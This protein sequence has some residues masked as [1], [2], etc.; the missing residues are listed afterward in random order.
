VADIGAGQDEGDVQ[1]LCDGLQPLQPLLAGERG[2]WVGALPEVEV[3]TAER[4]S[5]RFPG[6][7]AA[8]L[9]DDLAARFRGAESRAGGARGVR[10]AESV[11]VC[12]GHQMVTPK[13]AASC[14]IF[15]APRSASARNGGGSSG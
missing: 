10:G 13:T 9:V 8:L 15:H 14:V 4:R 1:Q 7:F 11:I 6:D 3:N 5:G 2:E 12:H